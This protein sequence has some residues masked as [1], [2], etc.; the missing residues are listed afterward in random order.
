MTALKN[1]L[2]IKNKKTTKKQQQQKTLTGIHG[3]Q[4]GCP[5]SAWYNP[6]R[7]F[8]QVNNPSI[9]LLYWPAMQAT[10]EESTR[11]FPTAQASQ[12]WAPELENFPAEQS[13]H[14]LSERW[15]AAISLSS[16]MYLLAAHLLHFTLSISVWSWYWPNVQIWH[17]VWSSN[18]YPIGHLLQSIME[19]CFVSSWPSSS[20]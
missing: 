13:R 8:W 11:S 20:M 1:K 18:S 10:H 16:A 5:G 17:S 15:A 3:R 6:A 2:Q 9:N 12:N 7:Q 19:S 4:N 14:E